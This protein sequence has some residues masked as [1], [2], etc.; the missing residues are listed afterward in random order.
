MKRSFLTGRKGQKGEDRA[1]WL[2]CGDDERD[3]VKNRSRS[4]CSP[5]HGAS[6]GACE[7]SRRSSCC[8]HVS[9]AEGLTQVRDS[10]RSTDAAEGPKESVKK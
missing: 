8:H 1:T 3:R 4:C 9:A 7:S 5:S 6:H 2:F 10:A